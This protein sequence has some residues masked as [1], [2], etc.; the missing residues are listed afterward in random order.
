MKKFIFIICLLLVASGC[1]PRWI[2]P[3][4]GWLI[5]FYVDDYISLN[6]QQSSSL[7]K[8]L[9]RVLDWHCRTQLPVYAQ[10]LRELAKD[11]EDPRRP[12]S[13]ERLQYYVNQFIAHWRDLSKQIGPEMADILATASDEQLAELFQNIEKKN[14]KFKSD[15]VDIPLEKQAEKRKERITKDIKKGISRLTAEQKQAV[16]DWSDQITPLAADGLMYRERVLTEFR[17][18]LTKRRQEPNFKQAFVALLVNFDQLRTRDYQQKIDFNTDLTLKLFIKIDRSLTATQRTYLL[19]RIRS[20][21]ADFDKLSCDP[22][23]VNS[24]RNE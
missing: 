8:R 24:T 19:K 3:H 10:S 18:L 7:E 16:S 15:Y 23:Q 22:V 12:I 6:R 9:L 17:N 21:A 11:L 13:Y 2:Y 1:G 5:P 14:K 20:M 4:L